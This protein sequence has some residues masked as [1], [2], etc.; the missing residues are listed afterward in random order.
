M[1]YF[2]NANQKAL[3]ILVKENTV[4]KIYKK[5]NHAY[6]MLG[7]LD[8]TVISYCSSAVDCVPDKATIELNN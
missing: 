5:T 7:L 4:N 6:M 3:T 2:F 1:T 8:F